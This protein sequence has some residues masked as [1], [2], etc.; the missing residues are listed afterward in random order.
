MQRT[1]LTCAVVLGVLVPWAV[2]GTGAE[3]FSGG[4][5]DI[6]WA[7][8][9][10]LS[11][12]VVLDGDMPVDPTTAMWVLTVIA[13]RFADGVRA[14]QLHVS[15]THESVVVIPNDFLTTR[16]FGPAQ[17]GL[18][19]AEHVPGRSISLR[20]PRRGAIPEL[21]APGDRLEV[22][23]LWVQ[24][25]PLVSAAVPEFVAG[26]ETPS[27]DGAGGEVALLS[28]WPVPE[29]DVIVQGETLRHAFALLDPV[30]GDVVPW[31][32]ATIGLLRVR[33]D[34]APEILEYLYRMPDP[35]T[36]R[37]E[38]AFETDKLEEGIYELIVW[39]SVSPDSV[40]RRIRVTRAAG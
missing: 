11:L 10:T 19:I 27:T 23:A 37:I 1:L 24:Q 40:R 28:T 9:T 34:E 15:P 7:D 8:E 30:T 2:G 13:D 4:D 14:W 31:G 12:V 29:I 36:G 39:T 16:S 38:Y 32:A 21:V 35:A 6:A 5:L 18:E 20:I 25:P 26:V 17:L 22:H 3:A 33:E